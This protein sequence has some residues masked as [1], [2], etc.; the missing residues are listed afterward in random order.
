[1]SRSFVPTLS[2]AVFLL[3][4]PLGLLDGARVAHAQG[5][6]QA[7]TLFDDAKR[8]ALANQ[9]AKACPLLEES[10]R[11]DPGLGTMFN[12]A[13]C[14]E[15]VGR[16]AAALRLFRRVEAEAHASVQADRENRAHDRAV[17]LDG[18]VAHLVVDVPNDA[19]VAD[20]RVIRDGE[21]MASTIWGTAL[22]IDVGEHEIRA[23]APG[24]EPWRTVITV[25][26]NGTASSITVPVLAADR[27]AKPAVVADRPPPTPHEAPPSAGSGQRTVALVVGGVGLAGL[28]TGGVFGALSLAKHVECEGGCRGAARDRQSA[29]YVFGNISSVAFSVG[30]AALVASVV[31][32]FTAPSAHACQAAFARSP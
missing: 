15:H 23:E 2:A 11:L 6:D 27:G 22:P 21:P 18:K 4:C 29:A 30:A 32:W 24:R 9:Y 3:A 13:D 31:L 7:Q 28:G 20:L 12:L 1:M 16:M 8:L 14:Y 19:R 10:L 17:A 5:N 25:K 26:D